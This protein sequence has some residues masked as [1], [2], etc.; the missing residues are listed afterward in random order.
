[1]ARSK[2]RRNKTSMIGMK[3]EED[4]RDDDVSDYNN[5]DDQEARE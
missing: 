2:V 4:D 5:D 3:M 1:M